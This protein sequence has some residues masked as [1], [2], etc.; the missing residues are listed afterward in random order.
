ML[1]S[2]IDYFCPALCSSA[3]VVKMMTTSLFFRC[4]QDDTET[5]RVFTYLSN[6]SEE[7][8]PAGEV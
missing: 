7:K 1:F 2:G 8:L 4:Q 6:D 5:G 3:V